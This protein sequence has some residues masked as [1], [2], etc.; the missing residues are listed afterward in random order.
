MNFCFTTW[1]CS[2]ILFFIGVRHTSCFLVAVV[3]GSYLREPLQAAMPN[4][5]KGVPVFS[6]SIGSQ[7]HWFVFPQVAILYPIWRINVT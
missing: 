1:E 4:A 6:I 7:D 2:H 5:W 3:S